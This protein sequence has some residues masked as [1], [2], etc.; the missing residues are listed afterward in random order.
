MTSMEEQV[1]GDPTA[2]NFWSWAGVAIALTAANFG[3][4]YGTARSGVG[5]ASMSVTRP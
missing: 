2:W 5:I 1:M 4:A 3:S